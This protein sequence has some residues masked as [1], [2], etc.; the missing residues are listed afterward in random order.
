MSSGQAQ[1]EQLLDDADGAFEDEDYSRAADLARKAAKHARK[2]GDRELELDAAVVEVAALNQLGECRAALARA[3]ELLDRAPDRTD[4]RVERAFALYELCRFDQ[5]RVAAEGIVEAATDEA[6]AAQAHHLLGLLAERAGDSREA[7]RR[8][9]LAR[10]LAPDDHPAPATLSAKAF[11]A[12]VEDALADIPPAV[13]D[14]LAN[15]PV[16]VEELPS[17]EDLLAADP[18]LSPSILGLFR[19]APYGDKGSGSPWS[20]FPSSIVLFQRNLER[21]AQ[22]REELIEEIR[23]TLVHEVGHFLGL[24]EEELFARGLD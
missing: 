7:Q 15:V 17:E 13:R 16:T 5:A 2:A 6:Q 18:P 3:D 8:F 20:H 11:D 10:R 24:D 14:Y 9:A 21:F 22:D 12:A 23:V 4:A 1:A 19:G